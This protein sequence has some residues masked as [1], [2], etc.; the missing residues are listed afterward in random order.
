MDALIVE[1]EAA[2]ERENRLRLRAFC[3]EPYPCSA[4]GESLRLL[5]LRDTVLLQM[6]ENPFYCGGRIDP[7]SALQALY[8]VSEARDRGICARKFSARVAKKFGAAE[9]C[10][11]AARYFDEMFA[12]SGAPDAPPPAGKRKPP[13]YVNASVYV[14]EIASTYGWDAARILGLPMA[15]IYQYLHLIR[16]GRNPQYRWRQLSDVA[17]DKIVRARIEARKR[18]G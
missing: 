7:V 1:F 18:K 8:V 10:T 4:L 13:H 15:Q 16:E 9:I 11:E 3:G 6:A 2:A 12:D 14:D 17:A 5:T